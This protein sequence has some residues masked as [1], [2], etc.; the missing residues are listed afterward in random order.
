[1][2][3]HLE[4]LIAYFTAHPQIAL[5]AVFAAS[6]LEALALIGVFI[7]GSTV[8]FAGGILIGLGVLDPYWTIAIAITGAILGDGISYWIGHHYQ[9]RIRTIWPIKAHPA[10]LE[11]G[12]AYFEA[13]GGKSVFFGR[14]F[15][16]VRAIVPVI[17]GMSGMPAHRFYA[18]NVAS[19]FAWALAHLLPGLLFG[20]SL[21][22]AGAVSSRLVIL[23]VLV[24][25]TLWALSK[26]VK[27]I[28]RVSGSRLRTLRDHA[29]TRARQGHGFS[30]R[31]ALSLLDPARPE[32]SALLMA[33]VL[34]T[35]GSWLFFTALEKVVTQDSLIQL[36]QAV[37]AALQGLRTGW[38]DRLMVS[39]AEA[40]GAVGTGLLIAGVALLLAILRRWHTLAYWLGGVAAAEVFALLLQF[41]LGR[42]HPDGIYVDPQQF[43]LQSGHTTLTVVA[44][45]FLAFLLAHGKSEREK[46]AATLVAMAL[47]MLVAFSRLY[48]GL[49]WLSHVW[50]GLGLG[51]VWLALLSIAYIHHLGPVQI[52]TWPLLLTILGSLVLTF[53]FYAG[54]KHH[55][56]VARYAARPELQAASL[57][58]WTGTGWRNLPFARSERADKPDEPFSVQWAGDRQHISNALMAAGWQRPEK[59]SL[60]S[61][62][63][64]LL[65]NTPLMDLPVLPK[66]ERGERQQITFVKTTAEGQR[67][68]LRLWPTRRDVVPQANSPAQ[69]LFIGMVTQE[70]ALHPGGVVT[71]ART[72][73][74]F[75]L[76]LQVLLKDAIAQKLNV[77][78]RQVDSQTIQ[79]LW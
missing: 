37:Y 74:D 17:A 64:W 38:G 6:L 9:D 67:L 45:G 18:M 70:L 8:V 54:P 20:A 66:L 35:A 25:A 76:P 30:A 11:R 28:Y 3:S 47:V 79:L 49:H 57:A 16:P 50:A 63:L 10:L 53:G 31:L 36:N 23:L 5:A 68:V 29:V 58:D 19:A 15:G 7:P 39:V 48:L 46:V 61:A 56:D 21:Q 32:S 12:Q 77:E 42:M 71:L 27:L 52:R 43:A 73:T 1:M 4:Q 69:P 41:T 14:F 75:A 78:A 34:L 72:A 59:W 22:L 40:G 2:E 65:P 51:L 24:A 60:K 13:N 55:A 33:G 26:L 62:L 44:Y